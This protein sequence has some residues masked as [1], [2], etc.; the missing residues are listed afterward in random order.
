MEGQ[1]IWT[2]IQEYAIRFFEFLMTNGESNFMLVNMDFLS[3]TSVSDEISK[4]FVASFVIMTLFVILASDT[5][6]FFHR[7]Q[8]MFE[9]GKKISIIKVIVF[10]A[11]VF[12]LHI[13]YKMLVALL[14]GLFHADA[15]I[16]AL[17]CLGS[18]I[19]PIALMIYAYAVSTVKL[20]N[21]YVQ[22]V[23]LGWSVF[24]TPALMSFYEIT[25]E[26][27]T[28]CIV[29]G[30][31]GFL[32]G[33][34]YH[35][36]APYIISF[37][38]YTIYFIAKYFMI[39]YSNEVIL[40]SG[41]TTVEKIGQYLACIEID[42]MIAAVL[43][44]SMLGYRLATT[45]EAINIKKESVFSLIIVM[46][47]VS[48]ILSSNMVTMKAIEVTKPN[49]TFVFNE[50]SEEDDKQSETSEK[51]Q[52]FKIIVSNANIRT[53]PGTEYDVVENATS[54]MMFYGTGKE[55]TTESGRVWYEIYLDE[56]CTQTGW[57]S[58][59]VIEKQ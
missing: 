35:R 25:N 3:E 44:L 46:L 7:K 29:G 19:N 54:D 24:L 56:D 59:K 14:S 41:E 9:Q 45:E 33:I 26:H 5:F 47:M 39:Y 48:S 37:I 57:A 30:V 42:L 22:S 31:L 2:K 12:S 32:G 11:T 6:R 16:W 40:L 28:L 21:R 49:N 8:V 1:I 58:E 53:G 17:D 4:I 34:L 13:F 50:N 36:L 27:I 18:Y 10:S 23:F 20:Q 15:S 51:K 38:M 52:L 55:V 43:M